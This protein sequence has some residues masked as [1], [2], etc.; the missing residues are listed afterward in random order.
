M[1][2]T[3][4]LRLRFSMRTLFILTAV[5]AIGAAIYPQVRDTH[6]RHTF[7][8]SQTAPGWWPSSW[9]AAYERMRTTDFIHD[10]D[11]SRLLVATIDGRHAYSSDSLYLLLESTETPYEIRAMDWVQEKALLRVSGTGRTQQ[12]VA[13]L[14]RQLTSLLQDAQQRHARGE[15]IMCGV[16]PA[17]SSASTKCIRCGTSLT[18][19]TQK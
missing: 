11:V 19:V 6:I 5:A 12:E 18:D 7:F 15:C 10:H 16:F 17:P 13:S 14:L 3:R 8:A 2:T 1:R 9:T 4:D